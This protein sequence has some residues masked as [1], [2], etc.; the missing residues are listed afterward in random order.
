MLIT[1]QRIAMRTHIL[2][3]L[4]AVLLSLAF[5]DA[6]A[7]AQTTLRVGAQILEL[8]VSQRK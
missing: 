4:I 1:L 3:C 2:F 7:I 5:G 6:H 8:H